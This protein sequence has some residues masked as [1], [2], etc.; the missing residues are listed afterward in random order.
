MNRFENAK[1]GIAKRTLTVFF[2]IDNSGSMEGEKIGAVKTAIK[3]VLPELKN[4]AAPNNADVE[5]KVAALIFSGSSYW[6]H[7]TLVNDFTWK[8]LTTENLTNMGAALTE[9]RSKLSIGDGGTM[10]EEKACY[11][12]VFIFMSDGEP[13]DEVGSPL[14]ALWENKWFK[15]GTRSAIAIGKDANIDV[16]ADLVGSKEGV[17]RVHSPETLKKIIKF[18]TMTATK[19]GSSGVSRNTDP[20]VKECDQGGSVVSGPDD[21]KDTNNKG[22]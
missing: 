11:A 17:T 7:P 10:S 4:L 19:S 16:L 22:W 14:K 21:L 6:I 5:I 20:Q 2:V 13:T 18:V 1:E 15:H 12:P 9:L 8:D 3:D